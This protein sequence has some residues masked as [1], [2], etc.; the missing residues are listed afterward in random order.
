MRLWI[1]EEHCWGFPP[2]LPLAVVQAEWRVT[3]PRNWLKI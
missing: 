3:R 1:P 2:S